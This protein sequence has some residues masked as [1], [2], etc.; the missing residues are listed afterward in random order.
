[1]YVR[2]QFNQPSV[3]LQYIPNPRFSNTRNE[4][5]F[6]T[7]KTNH[8]ET[9]IPSPTPPYFRVLF[10]KKCSFTYVMINS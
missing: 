1:M 2:D 4:H 10:Q 3:H 7:N 6:D 9:W 5:L 8:V